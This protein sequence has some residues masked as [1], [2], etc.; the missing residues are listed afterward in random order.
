MKT[1]I[2]IDK[3]IASYTFEK[4]KQNKQIANNDLKLLFLNNAKTVLNTCSPEIINSQLIKAKERLAQLTDIER[5]EQWRKANNIR[6]WDMVKVNEA[7]Y[8]KF[9]VTELRNK[10]KLLEYII[11]DSLAVYER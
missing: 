2:D 11:E 7:Y 4:Q 1:I 10:V 3:E 8:K 9:G 5:I 6:G